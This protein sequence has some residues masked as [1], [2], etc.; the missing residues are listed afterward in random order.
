VRAALTIAV[1]DATEIW[2]DGRF[3]FAAGLLVILLIAAIAGGVHNQSEIAR[4]HADAQ[5][6]ERDVWLDKGDMNPHAAAHY[7]AFVF[8]PVQPLS[9]ID[10][11]LDPFVGV[12][13]FL[14]AHKQQL[15]RH[16]PIEDA[17]PTRRL[18]QLTPASAALVLLPLLVVALTFSSFAGER[19]QGT[20]RPL[21]AMGISRGSLLAGK[22]VGAMLPLAAV[23]VPATIVGAAILFWNAPADPNAPIGARAAGLG[24]LY[25]VHTLIW[26]G[27]GLAISARSRTQGAALVVLLAIWFANA[28]ILPSLAMAAAKWIDPSPSAI[29]FAASIQDE[30]DSWPSWDARVE[31][32]MQ[33]F[34]D[35]EFESTMAPAN[36][37]V[38]ALLESE[39]DETALYDRRF[40]ELFERY[41]RQARSFEKVGAIAPTLAARTLSMALAGTDESHDRE[42]AAAATRYRTAMLT[43]LNG[44]LASSGRFNTFD[45]TRG[46]DL[47][48]KVPPFDY[49]VPS[50]RWAVSQVAWSA[51]AL[52][53]WLAAIALAAAWSVS[54]MRLE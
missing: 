22:A 20:L 49:D 36:V 41:Q 33:R 15:A 43:T 6:A 16:R 21:L 26:I 42:F 5:R 1:K 10:P 46:R 8:K 19:D 12:F 37:E 25:L 53:A 32:V 34:L 29:E 44:E 30:K 3:R 35:G 13:V 7:G 9:A 50:A 23:I 39:A 14:E 51:G 2:R 48:E 27:L 4:Q 17:T 11:G 47:W 54:S 40:A 52:A 28:F 45:Y 18:G 38:V 24:L 31:G